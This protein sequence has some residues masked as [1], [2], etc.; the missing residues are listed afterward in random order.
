YDFE[1][2]LHHI[3]PCTVICRLMTTCSARGKYS[4]WPHIA[5]DFD[6]APSAW[7]APHTACAISSIRDSL[8]VSAAP[9]KAMRIPS[10]LCFLSTSTFIIRLFLRLSPAPQE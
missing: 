5:C 1:K 6:C 10:L 9:H 4:K 7:G 8:S 2:G 3:L